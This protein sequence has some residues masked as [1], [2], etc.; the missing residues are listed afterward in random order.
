MPSLIAIFV[1]LQGAGNG[2]VSIVRPVL[3]ATLLSRRNFGAVSGKAATAFMAGTAFGPTF[4]SLIWEIGGYDLVINL[5]IVMPLVGLILL[6]AAAR[7]PS[8]VSDD[9][10]E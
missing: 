9:D 6:L 4:G 7:Y 3:I 8:S 5:A 2:V 1:L 10:P